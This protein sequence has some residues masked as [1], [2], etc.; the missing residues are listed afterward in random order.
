MKKTN[1]KKQQKSKIDKEIIEIKEEK[2]EE[3][4][5]KFEEELVIFKEKSWA[6]L[7]QKIVEKQGRKTPDPIPDNRTPYQIRTEP[8]QTPGL[9]TRNK[10]SHSTGTGRNR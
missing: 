6:N 5:I 2:E 3:K 4:D 9:S 7:R 8:P 10:F 1:R